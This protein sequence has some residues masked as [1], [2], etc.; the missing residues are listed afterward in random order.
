[1][2]IIIISILTFIIGCII[3]LIF[4]RQRTHYVP[5]S[6]WKFCDNKNIEQVLE[7]ER[8]TKDHD[9]WLLELSEEIN[10]LKEKKKSFSKSKKITTRNYAIATR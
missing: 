8:L 2:N 6:L 7:L 9:K 3:G 1:M 5:F 10:K 4:F